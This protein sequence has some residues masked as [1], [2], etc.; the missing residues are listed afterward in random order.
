V[1]ISEGFFSFFLLRLK[2]MKSSGYKSTHRHSQLHAA[3]ELNMAA[4]PGILE[5][6]EFSH[7]RSEASL[8]KGCVA[9]HA[10]AA[11]RL[12]RVKLSLDLFGMLV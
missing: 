11:Q 12:R 8:V 5:A 10:W 9:N 2:V 7:V 6:Q 3:F 1:A 4:E